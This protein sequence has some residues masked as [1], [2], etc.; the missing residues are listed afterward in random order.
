MTTIPPET[1]DAVIKAHENARQALSNLY[2]LL[3]QLPNQKSF[4]IKAI[5]GLPGTTSSLIKLLDFQEQHFRETVTKSRKLR[6][7]KP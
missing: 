4:R 5:S 1:Y 7:N 3:G 2:H 6:S